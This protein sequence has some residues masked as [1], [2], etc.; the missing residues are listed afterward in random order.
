MCKELSVSSYKDLT[1]IHTIEQY[2]IFN[3]KEITLA[4]LLETLCLL[5][6]DTNLKSS[7]LSTYFHFDI[8]LFEQE[9]ECFIKHDN[10]P[11]ILPATE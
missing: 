9:K 5:V 4:R 1:T 6:I 3:G 11:L 7:N 8:H 2:I 10:A